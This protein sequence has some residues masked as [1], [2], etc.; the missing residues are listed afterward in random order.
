[1]SDKSSSGSSHSLRSRG[2][3]G[4]SSV[5]AGGTTRKPPAV[6]TKAE[7]TTFL[8]FLVLAFPSSGD[9]GFKMPTFNQASINLNEKYPHQR[10]AEKTGIVFK[11]IIPECC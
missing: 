10:G 4:V 5:A 3:I 7:E 9:G 8:E 2:T 1:M 11:E 6:W